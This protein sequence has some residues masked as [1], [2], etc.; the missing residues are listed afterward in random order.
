M[1]I[2]NIIGK[3]FFA[4]LTL[5]GFTVISGCAEDTTATANNENTFKN[6][7]IA[8]ALGSFYF[9]AE[10]KDSG[11]ELWK[12]DG[13][14]AGTVMV[15]EI[16]Q[17]GNSN[18]GQFVKA[19]DNVFFVADDKAHGRELWVKK[20]GG[21]SLLLDINPAELGPDENSSSNIGFMT[22][23]GDLLYFVA[24]DGTNG[25][26][27]WLSDGTV[28]G[29]RMVVDLTGDATSSAITSLA[30]KTGGDLYFFVNGDTL[31]R[32][33]GTTEGTVPVVDAD[34]FTGAQHLTEMGGNL[35]FHANNHLWMS[36]GENDGTVA[37][38]VVGAN[39][40]NSRYMNLGD[41][42]LFTAG[43]INPN[44][45]VS[46]G[47]PE[48]TIQ[49][50]G[51]TIRNN[52]TR[53]RAGIV[54]A[55][56][57]AFFV[58][59]SG[60]RYLMM[61]NGTQEGTVQVTDRVSGN[62]LRLL[63]GT[64][65]GKVI[66]RFS[67]V[68]WS[69]DGT[70][71]GTIR[72]LPNRRPQVC[73]SSSSN[74]FCFI[75]KN[76]SGY[77]FELWTTDGSIAGT[78]K[79]PGISVDYF[80]S[81]SGIFTESNDGV[82]F[83]YDDSVHGQEPW[84]SDG[85]EAGSMLVA[86]VNTKP[87][88]ESYPWLYL[89]DSVSGPRSED[90]NLYTKVSIGETMYFIAD[91]GLHGDGL[92]KTDGTVEGTKLVKDINPDGYDEIGNMMV[93]GS[94]LY[95]TANDGEHGEELWVTDGTEGGTLMIF[96]AI[97]GPEDG[98]PWLVANFNGKLLFEAE[99]TLWI[100][101]GTVSGTDIVDIGVNPGKVFEMG[102]TVLIL[103][104][105]GYPIITDGTFEGTS[106]IELDNGP[107]LWNT[108][109]YAELKGEIYFA[110]YDNDEYM[111][112][113][114]TDGT[115]EGTKIVKKINESESDI[116]SNY[117]QMIVINDILYFAA[118]TNENGY[119]LWTSDGTPEGTQLLKDIADGDDSY[120]GLFNIVGNKLVFS[121]DDGVHGTELWVSDGTTDGTKLLKEITLESVANPY[122][123]KMYK[124][125]ERLFFTANDGINGEEMWVTDGTG[126]GTQLLKDINI[127]E[128]SSS[129]PYNLISHGDKLF[130]TAND[131][132]HGQE[133]WVSDGTT[134]GT[135]MLKDIVPGIDSSYASAL[136]DEEGDDEDE[137]FVKVKF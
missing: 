133:M 128:G 74:A 60:P 135:K 102:D 131:G 31:Y 84:F 69:S 4:S 50:T 29:T 66:L 120:P 14:E 61:T 111:R 13:T 24:D 65:D 117:Q 125:G 53:P 100:T 71:E 9:K 48:G 95:F 119:E 39:D 59:N 77:G 16:N 54:Q 62:D 25:A 99:N 106:E 79:V 6:E 81:E 115:V 73:A 42:L 35:F 1:K 105:W 26:E 134:D 136:Y 112:L 49:I 3:V 103:N 124:M 7:Y 122:I 8:P 89:A 90:N 113:W 37:L 137:E 110:A 98:R 85:T 41:K 86:D 70:D 21:T 38:A 45:W 55:G 10:S 34:A 17:T 107:Y 5:A 92:W 121:A 58:D 83:S 23:H 82:Y 40:N 129:Y 64:P 46:N 36:N 43:N 33:N 32:S 75:E 108:N 68:M 130:F 97:P 12:T 44:L 2:S 15:K 88:N 94:K 72:I 109:K 52:A 56:S 30:S 47:T 114:K 123:S 116:F 91:D 87:T 76:G 78:S 93:V 20:S 104:N 67:K 96:D 127:G 19:G 126:D 51:V 132:E 27:L 22:A 80:I 101:D 63:A 118:Y 11:T 28:E 57:V 18:P